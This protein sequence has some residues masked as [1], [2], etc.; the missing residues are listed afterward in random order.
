MRTLLTAMLLAAML[1]ALSQAQETELAAAAVPYLPSS[2][3]PD[4]QGFV[5]II[6]QSDERRGTVRIT[7]FDD[8]GN[9]GTNTIE[10]DLRAGQVKHFNSSDLE[11]GNENKGISEGFGYPLAGDWRLDIET[12]LDVRVL[13]FVRTNDGFLTAMHDVLPRDADRRLVAHTFNPGSNRSRESRLRLVNTGPSTANAVIE[14]V[15]DQGESAGPVTVRLPAGGARTLSAYDL[16]NGA[17]G[18]TGTLDD[19]AG[20]WRL[21]IT[22][23]QSVVGV[24]LLEASS[25][26][27]TNLSTMGVETKTDRNN[28]PSPGEDH[29]GGSASTA[30][31]LGLDGHRS[32]RIDPGDDGDYFMVRL[33]QSGTLTVYSTASTGRGLSATLWDSSRANRLVRDVGHRNTGGNFRIVERLAAGTYYVSVWTNGDSNISGYVVHADFLPDGN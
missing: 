11:L 12:A 5:R 2:S 21:Y 15:D 18:L 23:A 25:G 1:P 27:S 26:H 20:K 3:N 28:P 10:I 31:F 4:K 33:I 30:T 17:Q 8:E 29:H 22:A 16:E 13:A 32:G 24:S 7:A 14:G 6:N 9:R 19:G